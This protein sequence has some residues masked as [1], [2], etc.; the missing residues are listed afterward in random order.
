MQASVDRLTSKGIELRDIDRGLVDFPAKAFG[1][2]F[3]LCWEEG[4]GDE[5]LFAHNMG[6][7]YGSRL[8]VAEFLRR[9]A[10]H[11]EDVQQ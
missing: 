11:N 7:G 8:P 3:L 4:D 5:V 6:D 2:P 9:L 10:A 1:L